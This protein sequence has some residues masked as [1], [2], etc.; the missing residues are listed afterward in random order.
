[1]DQDRKP[2]RTPEPIRPEDVLEFEITDIEDARRVLDEESV[3]Q[4]D[5]ATTGSPDQW[6]KLRRATLPTDR[7]LS[8][9]GIDWLM[10]LPPSLR[11][12]QLSRRFPRIINGLA[13]VWD[14]P[15]ACHALF[16]RLLEDGRRGREGFPAEVHDELLALRAWTE[17]F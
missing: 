17:V 12:D 4:F 16:A 2:P 3:T 6:K 7:A 9:R 11:P 1:M 14:D 5:V 15:D 10:A 8:G 13:E